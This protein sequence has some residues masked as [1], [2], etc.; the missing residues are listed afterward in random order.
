MVLDRL[1]ELNLSM[2]VTPRGTYLQV[3]STTWNVPVIHESD[4]A[5]NYTR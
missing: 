1:E 3:L 4:V 2:S 5:L